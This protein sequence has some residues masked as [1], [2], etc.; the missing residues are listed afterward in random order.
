MTS[1]HIAKTYEKLAIDK[2][3]AK[4]EKLILSEFKT[5]SPA[6]SKTFD[7]FKIGYFWHIFLD[8]GRMILGH[9]FILISP[10]VSGGR[11]RAHWEQIG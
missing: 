3:Q 7:K 9:P 5:W 10:F 8:W 4:F 11:E 6:A 1:S 2:Q